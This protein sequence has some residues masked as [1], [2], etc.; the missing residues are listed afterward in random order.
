MKPAILSFAIGA[1]AT[2]LA[3]AAGSET[4]PTPTPTPFSAVSPALDVSPATVSL[5]PAA[6]PEAAT[7]QPPPAASSAFGAEGSQWGSIGYGAAD[8]FEDAVD[9]YLYF[10]WSTFLATDIELGLEGGLW[11]FNQPGDNEGGLSGTVLFRWHFIHKETWTAYIAAGIGVLIATGNVPDTGT[12][13]DLLPRVGVGITKQLTDTGLR[14]DLGL[15]W[16][17][18]SNARIH[19]DDDNPS[20][21]GLML[22][23]GLTFPF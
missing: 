1:A 16:H 21:D 15:R 5:Q 22:Y 19:G 2:S 14:L 11:Y 20:R 4:T 17:H 6:E 7:T 18:I 23:A 9:Q 3:S 8:N 10:T 13:F 12:S